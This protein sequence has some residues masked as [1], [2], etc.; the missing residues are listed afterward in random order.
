MEAKAVLKFVRVAP[1]KARMVVD[2]IRGKGAGDALNV[3]K[4]TTRHAARVIEKVLKSAVANAS[5]LN[6]G[7]LDDLFVSKIC[8]DGG[9][10]MK[11]IQPRAMGRSNTIRKRTS[12]I[13]LVLSPKEL[14]LKASAEGK[15]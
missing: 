4:F 11:R 2:L 10:T 7:D 1:R 9:P 3:L 15:S 8:V 6:I 12:H 5:V 14:P 13:T